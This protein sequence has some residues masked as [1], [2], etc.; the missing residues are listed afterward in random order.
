MCLFDADK[1]HFATW[2]CIYNE[3]RP[4]QSMA[5]IHPSKPEA[6]PLYYATLLGFRDLAKHLISEHPEHV[7]AR[8]GTHHTPMHAAAAAGQADILSL[9]IQGGVDVNSWDNGDRTP[10]F[11]A[12]YNG[13]L[14]AG[15]F[16]LNHGADIEARNTNNNTALIYAIDRD[17]IE[18]ARMLLERGAVVNFRCQGDGTPLH[19]AAGFGRI[20][21]VRL[22]LEHGA[23]A[24]ARDKF[25]YPPSWLTTHLELIELLSK[26]SALS[27]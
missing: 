17:D 20:K 16:L 8:G 10:L 25:G 7:S 9:L 21:L 3:D 11:L 22:L 14:E 6:I 19:R 5:S 24:N 27:L 2:L 13:R 15:E 1:P 23:D 26:F 12:P 4:S 18:F